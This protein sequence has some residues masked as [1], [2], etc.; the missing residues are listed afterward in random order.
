[1]NRSALRTCWGTVVVAAGW[2]LAATASG[3]CVTPTDGMVLT[4]DTTLCSGSYHLTNGL[5]IAADNI[6]V[7][8]ATSDATVL[9]GDG[10]GNGLTVDDRQHVTVSDLTI[11]AYYNGMHFRGCDYAR[12]EYCAVANCY[13]D[14]RVQPCDF[15]DIFDDPEGSGNS[16]GHAIWL[17]YCNHATLR[18]NVL[19]L[20]QNGISLFDCE[21]ALV[22]SNFASH[23]TGWGI[24]LYNTNHSTIQNNIADDCT[25]IGA[26]YTGGDAAALLMVMGSSYNQVLDNSFRRGGDGLFL[27]GYRIYKLPCANN[28]FARNDCSESPNNGFEA[29][30]SYGNVFDNNITDRCNYGYWLGYS[31]STEVR[32]GQINDC[33]TA[34]IAIEHGNTNTIQNNVM[35]GNSRGIWLWTDPDDDLVQAFP[36]LKDSYGY[37]IQ[38]NTITGGD[39]GI[40]C[41]AIGTNRY[42]REYTITGNQIDRNAYGIQFNATDSSTLQANFIRN[43]RAR[44]LSINFGQ[45]NTIS[46][47]YF[48][49]SAN[50]DAYRMNTWNLAKTPG[51][52]IVGGAFLAGN[53]WSDYAGADTDGD[54]IGN[55]NLPY[56]SG[57]RILTGGDYLPL[58]FDDP[59]CDQNGSPDA[60]EPDCNGNGIPDACDI[61]GGF[62][63][64]CNANGI[65]D[66]C[67]LPAARARTR[68]TT[69][70]RT[71]ARTA[72][73]TMCP[74]Q[75]TSPAGPAT[76]ATATAFRMS[77][78]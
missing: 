41:E 31:W 76:T 65:P 18:Y 12:I 4:A 61:A 37:A 36:E 35:N 44:G 23:H 57:G 25:R 33:V 3:Q 71:S 42:S 14:C 53:F 6:V 8:G 48:D 40:L 21:D 54:G 32:N 11:R 72:I 5:S 49:N 55:T 15:L 67:T 52:N 56:T 7:S 69:A 70:F 29:T 19:N 50:A 1:M 58:F 39:S 22:E 38:G 43:N 10:I 46:N 28:Y 59:D 20:Q 30:F 63:T 62:S 47:N 9:Y 51:A 74:T 27:A 13:N 73:A 78:I 75:S 68:T 17:R 2:G 60:G 16:Y 66:A 45:S 24:T 34:G 77:A 26:G 64:D